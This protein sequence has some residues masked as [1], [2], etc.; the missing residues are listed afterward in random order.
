MAVGQG[1]LHLHCVPCQDCGLSGRQLQAGGLS[2]GTAGR[3][4][5]DVVAH[6]P[7]SFV[8][9]GVEGPGI[10]LVRRGG[11]HGGGASAVQAEGSHTAQLLHPLRQH[12][13]G[14]AHAVAGLPPVNGIQH[15]VAVGLYA[16]GG[17]GGGGDLKPAL[18]RA[19]GYQQVQRADGLR[20]VVPTGVGSG[21]GYGHRLSRRQGP[22]K[23]QRIRV[24]VGRGGEHH[25]VF[26]QC[27]VG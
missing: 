23:C 15:Q 11:Y 3:Q 14:R 2:G 7:K 1:G 13:Q 4:Q 8:A 9:G 27:I 21:E 16:N 6:L 24:A 20:H 5:D 26:L 19:A 25:L 17:A 10:G 12:P 22:E 18:H